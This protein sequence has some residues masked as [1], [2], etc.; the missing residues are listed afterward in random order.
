[1][2]ISS[3]LALFVALSAAIAKAAPTEP[4][5]QYYGKPLN[6]IETVRKIYSSKYA[7][8]AAAPAVE[9]LKLAEPTRFAYEGFKAAHP[10]AHPTAAGS[11]NSTLSFA[12]KSAAY[13][14]VGN[15]M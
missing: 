10:A 3:S 11:L 13:Y 14:N 4:K 5:K 12:G 2:R 1:M 15:N 7:N 9:N 8:E 6:V